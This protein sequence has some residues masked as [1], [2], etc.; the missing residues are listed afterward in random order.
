VTIPIDPP[1]LTGGLG[2]A[3]I[4]LPPETDLQGV[5]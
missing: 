5:R 2:A 1:V 4:Y 3:L